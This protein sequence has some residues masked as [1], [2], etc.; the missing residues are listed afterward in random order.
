[1]EGASLGPILPALILLAAGLFAVLADLFSPVPNGRKTA[2]EWIAYLGLIASFICVYLQMGGD[3]TGTSA[4]SQSIVADRLSKFTSLTVLAAALLT[5]V[6][7]V[8]YVVAR[9]IY[10][11]EYV[12]LILL[13]TAGMMFLSMASDLITMFLAIEIMSIAMYVLCGILRKDERALES[14]LKYFVQGA[15]ASAFLLYGMALLYGATGKVHF[16]AIA[17]AFASGATPMATVGAGLLIVGFAFKLG[18]APFHYWVPDVYEGA[19]TSVTAFMSVAVKAAGFAGL[20]RVLMG[21]LGGMADSWQPVIVGIASLTMIWGNL[22]AIAQKS[23]KRM[24]AYSSVAHTGYA[25]VGIAACRHEGGAATLFYLFAYTFMTLGAFAMLI[26]AGRQ[27]K[28]AETFD[29]LAGLGKR[30]PLSAVFMTIFMVSLAGV[31]PT[32]GF[33]GKF[34]LF[35]AAV[36]ADLIALAVLGV[37]AA[38]VGAAYYLRVVVVMWMRDS[39]EAHAHEAAEPEKPDFNVGLAVLVAALLTIAFGVWPNQY[40]GMAQ[41]GVPGVKEWRELAEPR[42]TP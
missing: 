1:M 37:I 11:A 15:F 35:R 5:V 41:S 10:L 42:H 27:G 12:A 38:V 24:L 26:F 16:G 18:A 33:F 34:M 22:A 2:V 13:S 14:A 29:D 7:S 36:D 28:D 25:L 40:V 32:A 4:F 6:F 21:A 30:R 17:D 20:I 23:V 9:G 39:V 3:P 8:D 19:P 31:P